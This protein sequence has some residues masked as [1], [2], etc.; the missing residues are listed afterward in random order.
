MYV[1]FVCVPGGSE[2]A[3]ALQLDKKSWKSGWRAPCLG[4]IGI[5]LPEALTVSTMPPGPAAGSSAH[6]HALQPAQAQDAGCSG[7]LAACG[8][9]L[10]RPVQPAA[11]TRPCMSA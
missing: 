4:G 11:D 3:E 7:I 6:T 1:G 5:Y 2:G 8:T 9:H 10:A